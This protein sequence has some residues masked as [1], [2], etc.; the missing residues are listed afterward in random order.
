MEEF[1]EKIKVIANV[2]DS[3]DFLNRKIPN[4][5]SIYDKPQI[6]KRLINFLPCLFS[7]IRLFTS[8][9]L[10][11]Y[12]ILNYLSIN[13]KKA[14]FMFICVDNG[15]FIVQESSYGYIKYLETIDDYHEFMLFMNNIPVELRYSYDEENNSVFEGLFEKYF[16]GSYI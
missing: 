14:V 8:K 1:V 15:S 4:W 11:D 7:G 10:D 12:S 3:I 6:L 13:V 16:N 9:I 2:E 5:R